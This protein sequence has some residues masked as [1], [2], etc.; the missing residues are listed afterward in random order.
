MSAPPKA[1]IRRSSQHV[2]FV[3]G[4]DIGETSQYE[5][6]L[7]AAPVARSISC[8]RNMM[9][10]DEPATII[11]S[12]ISHIAV[13]VARLAMAAIVISTLATT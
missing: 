5:R 4:S 10:R 12:A 8:G 1:D 3:P 11:G 6:S 7:G 9:L 13:R 2:R